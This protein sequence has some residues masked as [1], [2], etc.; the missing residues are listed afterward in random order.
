MK[1]AI[2]VVAIGAV[3][4]TGAS[5]H[6]YED[7]YVTMYP[8]CACDSDLG[9]PG[10]AIIC[11]DTICVHEVTTC[12]YGTK[13]IPSGGS[14]GQV[15]KKFVT[16]G[17]AALCELTYAVCVNGMF[18]RLLTT[19]HVDLHPFTEAFGDWCPTEG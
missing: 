6:A 13:A 11:G 8:T 12:I 19:V 4:W 15:S 18:C 14:Y 3:S 16:G 9:G 7:C 17:P 1:L 5:T 10:I 2:A